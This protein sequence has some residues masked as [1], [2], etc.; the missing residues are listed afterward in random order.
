M[1]PRR[2]FSSSR[3]RS[4]GMLVLKANVLAHGQSAARP[5]LVKLIAELLNHNISPIMRAQGSLS[6]SGDLV[7]QGHFGQA[8][9]RERELRVNGIVRS[10]L[11]RCQRPSSRNFCP[12][13]RRALRWANGTAITVTWA[14]CDV[15]QERGQH[16]DVELLAERI[17][18]GEVAAVAVPELAESLC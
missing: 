8:L 4:A 6:A 15:D 9:T 12:R 3:H 1:M 16:A 2:S 7:P 5:E 10:A 13:R 18:V 14:L 11:R 17:R